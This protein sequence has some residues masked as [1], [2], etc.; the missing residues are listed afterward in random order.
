MTFRGLQSRLAVVWILLSLQISMSQG[1]AQLVDAVRRGDVNRVERLLERGAEADS[2][3]PDGTTALLWA[4]HLDRIDI[5]TLLV[6]AGS[7]VSIANRYGVTPA[8]QAA[9]NGN[10]ELMALFLEA[11]T[12]AN[13]KTPQGETLLMIAART[14]RTDAV[15]TLLG[16][17]A[18]PNTPENKRGQTALMWAAAEGHVHTVQTLL[19]AGANRDAESKKGFTAFLFAVRQGKINVVRAL[20][21]HKARINP[22]D[23]N[24]PQPEASGVF[25]EIEAEEALLNQNLDSVHWTQVEDEQARGRTYMTTPRA[26]VAGDWENACELAFQ[27][28]ITKPGDY[29]L[30]AY[31]SGPAGAN[32][33]QLGLDRQRISARSFEADNETWAWMIAE[34]PLG[35]TAGE[36]TI[37][38]RRREAGWKIDKIMITQ[39]RSDVP[40]A[41]HQDQTG[42]AL[43]MAVSN[44]HFDIAALLLEAGADPDFSWQGRT[45]LHRIVSVRKPGTGT[46]DPSPPGSGNMASLEVVQKL[47]EHGADLDLRMTTGGYVSTGATA[48]LLAAYTADAGLMRLLADLGADPLIPNKA[49]STPLMVAAG[50]GVKSPGEDAGTPSEVYQAVKVA[51]SLGGDVNAVNDRGETAMHG[52]AYKYADFVVPL[53]I[54]KGAK[55]QIWNQKNRQGWTPLRIAAG[56]H[57]TMNLRRSPEVAAELRKAMMAAGVST[58]IDPE[59]NISGGTR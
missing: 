43:C 53:L 14:G 49:H 38:I 16:R 13:A 59:I 7:K 37:R 20:L 44:A 55:I 12:D 48:F 17:G 5:A 32:S 4:A 31:Q 26:K 15:R 58:R 47:A 41:W 36:H 10:A 29:Y 23:P 25:M 56:I 57:R 22:S 46:H 21:Q 18:N 30:A 11:G 9:T 19:D 42:R 35:L 27:V 51:L 3:T 45:A 2:T 52:A 24:V 54:E 50:V 8:M 28:K 39:N 33:A 40:A 1:N 6:R 34:S